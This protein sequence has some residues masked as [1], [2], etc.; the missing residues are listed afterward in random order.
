MNIDINWNTHQH[1]PTTPTTLTI[2]LSPCALLIDN[3]HHLVDGSTG[4]RNIPNLTPSI[5]NQV[6][7]EVVTRWR[8]QTIPQLGEL[9]C[10]YFMAEFKLT[11]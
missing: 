11:V 10:E 4:E 2:N 9:S 6:N 8:E 5:Y 7:V 3:S 1:Q